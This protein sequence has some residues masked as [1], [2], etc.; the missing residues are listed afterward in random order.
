MN[1]RYIDNNS[2]EN[3]VDF[4][5]R[6]Y[7]MSI[8]VILTLMSIP[9]ILISMLY[10][11]DVYSR[12]FS[13]EINVLIIIITTAFLIFKIKLYKDVINK[14]EFQNAVFAN[15]LNHNT[16]FCLIVH[17][18]G[19]VIYAD[20][21]FYERFKAY[22]QNISLSNVLTMGGVVGREQKAF[23]KALKNN[24]SIQTY[25][26]FYKNNKTSN[27]LLTLSPISTNPEIAIDECHKVYNLSFIPIARPQEYFVLKATKISKE[28]L[29]EKL[30]EAHYIGIYWLNPNGVVVYANKSFLR[31]F[32]LE[33]LKKDT[34]FIDFIAKVKDK[35]QTKNGEIILCTANG[36]PFKA[37]ISNA[38]FYDKYNN[39][40]RCGLVTP[41]TSNIDDYQLNPCFTNAPVAIALCDSK[42]NFIKINQ[43]LLKLVKQK[44]TDSIFTLIV[45]EDHKKIKEY[46]E[47]SN[48]NNMTE[49]VKLQNNQNIK[50]YFNKYTHSNDIFII[51]YFID[52]TEHKNLEIK[53]EH[54]QKMQAIGQ[55]AGGIAHDFNNILTAI[56]GFCD[57]LLIRHTTNDHSFSDIMQIQQNAKRG[58]NLVKQLLAFSR[59]QTLQFK[60]LDVNSIVADLSQMIK[61]LI[62]EN[63]EFILD[64]KQDGGLVKADQGQLEQ[65][66]I[67]L[68][69]NSSAAMEKG[70]KLIIRTL[71]A[72]IDHTTTVAQDVFLSDKEPI[73]HG[74]YIVIE[75]IDNGCGIKKNVIGNIFEPFFS[76]KDIKSGT[77]LGLSTVYGIVKQTGG[78]I[79]VDSKEGI[80]SKF[81]IF[82][83]AVHMLKSNKIHNKDRE[84]KNIATIDIHHGGTVLL[85]ED[86]DSVRIFSS[87]ALTKKGYNIIEA[88]SGKR[89]IAII[90][91]KINKI[92]VIITD[93]VMPEV[94]GPEI[95][96]EAIKIKPDVKIIFI[97]GYAEDVFLKNEDINIKEFHFLPKPFTLN[98]I[99]M[100][101]KKV[102]ESN[103]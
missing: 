55:L 88:D 46:L 78:Y 4:V 101:I 2:K 69:V 42:G 52:N 100:K 98:E 83:P 10:L 17:K 73:E 16:E 62:G 58:S 74:K 49:D 70:G 77:G 25:F 44:S 38:V 60:I 63:I 34:L 93:V 39:R 51:C 23:Y 12:H 26:S 3:R 24:S 6:D 29:Y 97:S 45:K 59:K 81:S 50:V 66:I 47:S 40:Y 94:S 31:M 96:R 72:K 19:S 102:L 21:R 85:I 15:A 64:Y 92:D 67:N 37:H 32:E 87:R 56:I 7:G 30:M 57:L 48:I 41:V 35:E 22:D 5:F 91:E 71:K 54:Y 14:V 103:N 1:K 82:L 75:V 28:Q 9:I 86:E 89:A 76:T 27:F 18:S 68:V 8:V 65:V 99:T 11:F 61:R 20:A 79:M 95:A 36:I 33:S 53:F 13:I 43:A 90:K 80:G 84:I